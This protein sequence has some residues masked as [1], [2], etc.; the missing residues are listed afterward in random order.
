MSSHRPCACDAKACSRHSSEG[1]TNI[2]IGQSGEKDACGANWGW[3]EEVG[4]EARLRWKLQRKWCCCTGVEKRGGEALSAGSGNGGE[5]EGTGTVGPKKRRDGAAAAQRQR[6]LRGLGAVGA[7]HVRSVPQ[8]EGN[9][10]LVSVHGGGHQ[11]RCVVVIG[12]INVSPVLQ[13]YFGNLAVAA[14][15]AVHQGCEPEQFAGAVRIRTRIQQHLNHLR[16]AVRGR[17]QQ[18]RLAVG[19]VHVHVQLPA[20][21]EQADGCR[22][23]HLQPSADGV[24]KHAPALVVHDVQADVAAQVVADQHKERAAR[25]GGCGAYQRV[26]AV[27]VPLVDGV[28]VRLAPEGRRRVV[29]EQQRRV[30][31]QLV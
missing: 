4:R 5:R 11:G 1:K 25:P 13:Q 3:G 27:L 18:Q 10:L 6:C 2:E 30:H 21:Y 24:G 26:H 23:V 31:V 9:H 15:H 20:L 28:Q 14:H 16:A 7:V 8:Q 19:R 22:R 12:L 29:S 17:Q